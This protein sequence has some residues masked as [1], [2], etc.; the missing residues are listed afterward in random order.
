[1]GIRMKRGNVWVSPHEAIVHYSN[2]FCISVD[3]TIEML[4]GEKMMY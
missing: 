3:E 2:L 4:Y 1:M